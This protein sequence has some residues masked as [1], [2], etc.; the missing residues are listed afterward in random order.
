MKLE[1]TY[2]QKGL[3]NKLI[4][5]LQA[6]GIKDKQVLNTINL[7]PRHIFFDQALLEHAYQD[8]AFPIGQGQTISQPYTVARQTEL[9]DLK[10]GLKVLEIGTGS[11]YQCAILCELG[12]NVFSIEI[13]KVLHKQA[14]THLKEL[15]Y[16]PQLFCGDGTMGLKQ[17][18]PFDRILVTAGAPHIPTELVKQLKPNGK[19][20]LPVGNN[21]SQTMY[22][23]IKVN[24]TEVVKEKHGR[25]AFVPLIGK[26]GWKD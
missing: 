6:K 25:F 22:R 10:P 24:D 4:Q 14:M 13:N 19:L 11:G 16:N 7:M 17:A 15:S 5:K 2:R 23:I 9:L 21:V 3:R 12:C 8:K 20:V 1:D 26:D 18:A